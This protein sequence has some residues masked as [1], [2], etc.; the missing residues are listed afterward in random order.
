MYLVLDCTVT[1]CHVPNMLHKRIKDYVSFFKET[2]GIYQMVWH[3]TLL[4]ATKL[5]SVDL[6]LRAI[7][8]EQAVLL[9]GAEFL[10]P[11]QTLAPEQD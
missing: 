4:G 11:E 10:L 9:R 8:A 5:E 7:F 3:Q 6:A 2:N 1:I